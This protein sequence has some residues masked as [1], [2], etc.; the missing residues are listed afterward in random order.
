MSFHGFGNLV[1][2]VLGT[3]GGS[4]VSGHRSAKRNE[5]VGGHE[6]SLHLVG[7]AVDAEFDSAEQK[8]GGITMARRLGL[9]A[10]DEGDYV[11][12]QVRH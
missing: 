8:E 3:Y 11:H 5:A 7:L 4:V 10:I 12:I 2:L 1:A 6:F 9:M